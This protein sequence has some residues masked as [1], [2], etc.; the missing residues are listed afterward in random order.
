MKILHLPG[1]EQ[2]LIIAIAA[3]AIFII[4]ALNEVWGSNKVNKIEKIMWTS[5]FISIGFLGVLAG[6]IYLSMGRKCLVK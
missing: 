6:I 2:L 4:A 1:A 3:N 5:A